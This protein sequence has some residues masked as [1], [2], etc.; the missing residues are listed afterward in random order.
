MQEPDEKTKREVCEIKELVKT[1]ET[2]MQTFGAAH[3][4]DIYEV[5]ASGKLTPRPKRFMLTTQKAA[6]EGLGVWLY[7]CLYCDCHIYLTGFLRLHKK[8]GILYEDQITVMQM[9]KCITV[10]RIKDVFGGDVKVKNLHVGSKSGLWWCHLRFP[11][12][13]AAVMAM[14]KDSKLLGSKAYK[15]RDKCYVHTHYCK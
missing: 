14:T 10:P 8:N 1:Q 6:Y 11:S 12:P 13:E 3:M 2:L 15:V 9:E 5:D 7:P 4:P